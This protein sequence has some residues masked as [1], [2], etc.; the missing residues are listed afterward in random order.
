[1]SKYPREA[2]DQLK[3][4]D[5]YDGNSENPGILDAIGQ[6]HHQLRSYEDAITF[7]KDAI[8]LDETNVEFYSN[9]ARCFYDMEE[10]ALAAENLDEA[11][12]VNDKNSK[13]HY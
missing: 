7:Y 2:L 1:M 5:K 4:A 9:I 11:L 13:V 10:Y 12:K 8:K 3:I 6:A